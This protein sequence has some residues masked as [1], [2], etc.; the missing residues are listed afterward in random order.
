MNTTWKAGVMAHAQKLRFLITAAAMMVLMMQTVYADDAGFVSISKSIVGD[1]FRTVQ[2]VM[3]ITAC[4]VIIISIFLI[5]IAT[6]DRGVQGGIRRI[7]IAIV[8]LILAYVVPSVIVT[9]A[10]L[11]QEN[12][13]SSIDEVMNLN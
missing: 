7:K 10:S 5:I 12:G 2:S 9:I 3:A 4:L 1:I 13:S 8:C 11:A 6:D